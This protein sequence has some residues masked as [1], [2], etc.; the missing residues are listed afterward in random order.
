[1]TDDKHREAALIAD[2]RRLVYLWRIP[3]RAT[4]DREHCADRLEET[5]DE[6][7]AAMRYR[8]EQEKN[9]D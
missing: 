4:P 8:D 3:T 5:I 6:W 9:H 2:L 7:Q 1:M